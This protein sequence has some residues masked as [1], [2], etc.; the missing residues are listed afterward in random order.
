MLY[1]YFKMCFSGWNI[2]VLTAVFFNVQVFW[3]MTLCHWVSSFWPLKM[4][5]VLL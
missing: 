5:A 4:R 1:M 2:V 3:D